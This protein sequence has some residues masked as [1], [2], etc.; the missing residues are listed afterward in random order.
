MNKSYE[1]Y[2]VIGFNKTATTTL[3]NLF[4]K[5]NLKSQHKKS[6]F[7]DTSKYFIILLKRYNRFSKN[8][9]YID[10]PEELD[11]KKYAINY[12]KGIYERGNL[13][14]NKMGQSNIKY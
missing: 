11:I 10:I 4:L 12:R 2:F 3:H 9:S 8:N 1:K 5:N 6:Q 13:K 7:W 14:R